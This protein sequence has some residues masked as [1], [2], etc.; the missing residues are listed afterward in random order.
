MNIEQL[1]GRSETHLKEVFPG[2][3]LHENVVAPYL[4]FVDSA[5]KFGL[6]LRL[7]SGFRSFERQ[8][9]I[10]NAK[11]SGQRPVYGTSGVPI[12]LARLMDLDKVNAILRWSALPGASRH[13]WGTDVD[14][15]DRGA[16][17]V[18]YRL[19]LSPDEYAS[20]GVFCRLKQWLDSTLA[21]GSSGFFCPYSEDC[22]GVAPEPWHL[23]YRPLAV[24]FEQ[25][26]SQRVLRETLQDADILLKE[27]ILD[28]L[29]T[30][31]QRFV[32]NRL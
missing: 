7:A 8:L 25:Q 13:H 15:W 5:T 3:F 22:G 29:D 20:N 16:V 18:D 14:V 27:T 21:D 10:W 23:S 9:Q 30:I 12:D 6:Q 17:A 4:A 1:T 2:Y 26:L 11:V 19:Q 31:Y 24:D 32:R 28:N